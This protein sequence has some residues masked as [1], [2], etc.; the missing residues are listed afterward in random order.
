MGVMDKSV[1]ESSCEA[2]VTE[3]GVPL[4]ELQVGGDDKAPAFITI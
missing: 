3:D 1:N 4:A 2:V